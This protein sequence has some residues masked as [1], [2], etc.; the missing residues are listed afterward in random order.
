MVLLDF[1]PALGLNEEELTEQIQLSSVNVTTKSKGTVMDERSVLPKINNMQE[2]MKKIIST[3]QKTSK[4]D[5]VNIKYKTYQ[6][7]SM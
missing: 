1:V 6:S 2:N 4:S 3:T 7:V 5:L